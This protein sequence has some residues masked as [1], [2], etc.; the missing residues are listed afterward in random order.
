MKD[1]MRHLVLKE[2]NDLRTHIALVWSMLEEMMWIRKRKP[3]I[4]YSL[5]TQHPTKHFI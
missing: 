1:Q 2:T 3:F 4:G 5:C